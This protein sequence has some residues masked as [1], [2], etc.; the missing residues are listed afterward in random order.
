MIIDKLKLK[1]IRESTKRNYYTIWKQFNNFYLKLDKKPESWEDRIVLY[2]GHLIN[3]NRQS[4]TIKSYISALRAILLEDGF[5]L[6]EDK[7]LLSALVRAC[8]INNDRIKARFPIRKKML[9]KLLEKT[10]SYYEG[11]TINQPYL[12]ILYRTIFAT[13]YYGLFRVGEL[14]EGSHTVRVTDVHIARNKKKFLFILWTSKTHNRNSKP[15]AIKI[16]S[17]QIKGNCEN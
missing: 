13:A 6:Q 9:K 5:E 12:S 8:K 4:Q 10:K 2:V 14:T 11:E 3:K 16:S 17:T 7:F 1:R 15:Q